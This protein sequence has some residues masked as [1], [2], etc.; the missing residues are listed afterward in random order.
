MHR[1][2]RQ[3][4]GCRCCRSGTAVKSK[5]ILPIKPSPEQ[6]VRLRQLQASFAELCNALM[7]FVIN[8]RCWN[9]VGLHHLAYRS[10]RES[11]PGMGSQMVC[12][13]IYMVSR[14]CKKTYAAPDSPWRVKDNPDASLPKIHFGPNAPVFFDRNTLSLKGNLL[15]MFTPDGRIRFEVKLDTEL[16]Q[17]FATEKI[18]E[19][20]LASA[21]DQF[22]LTFVFGPDDEV[23][24]DHPAYVS[25]AAS[26]RPAAPMV[27]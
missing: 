8:N 22:F 12:N 6:A 19:I 27:Q 13:A 11:H 5:F 9:R 21:K 20:G 10:L 4:L 26:A 17:R 14:V 25:I 24:A 7:P 2:P 15:S 16:E 3:P 23:L 1:S 18:K